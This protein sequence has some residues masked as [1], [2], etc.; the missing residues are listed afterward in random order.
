MGPDL[1]KSIH[2]LSLRMRLMRVMQEGQRAEAL[3]ERESLILQQIAEQGP[4]NVSQIAEAWPNVSEST[5]SMTLTRLWK[6]RLVSKTVS[7]E[8]Q[9][10][11]LVDLTEQGQQ[12]LAAVLEQQRQ[13][14][15]TL[16]CAI[17]VTPEEKDVLIRIC[18]RG[19][20]FLDDILGIRRAVNQNSSQA[21]H[22]L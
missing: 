5:I 11:T 16:F 20:A 12:E 15:Q 13:R 18:Q 2:E 7:P 17:Q 6:R 22:V 4:M 19:V 9:R 8:N 14:F 10:M 21:E 1:E 3:T